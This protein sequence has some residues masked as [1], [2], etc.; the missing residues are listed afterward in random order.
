MANVQLPNINITNDDIDAANLPQLQKIVKALL[1]TTA[2]LTEELTF[3]LNNLDTRNVNEIDGDVLIEGT[4]TALK[5]QVEELSAISAN[6]GKI[7]AGQIFGNYIAT[8]EVGYPRAEMSNTNN[9]FQAS[10]SAGRYIQM[11]SLASGILPAIKLINDDLDG[12]IYPLTGNLRIETSSG[13]GDITIASGQDLRLSAAYFVTLSDWSKL[14][15]Y[16][17]GQTLQEALDALSSRI[18]ALGG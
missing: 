7:T 10:S 9:L 6:L 5:M 15:S 17:N 13:L 8:K 1:N 4:V 16:G 3:L 11:Q 18:T 12:S 2:I 14:Y